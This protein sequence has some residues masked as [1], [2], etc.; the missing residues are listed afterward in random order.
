MHVVTLWAEIVTVLGLGASAAAYAVAYVTNSG[1]S[2]VWRS[3]LLVLSVALYTL[4][5]GSYSGEH[6]HCLITSGM[7]VIALLGF[8]IALIYAILE[9]VTK[10]EASGVFIVP[11]V[12]L[13]E[14]ASALFRQDG[15]EAS[16]KFGTLSLNIHVVTAVFGYAGLS[17]SGM[18]G[19]MYLML[20]RSIK[21]STFGKAFERLPSLASLEELSLW[22]LYIGL[23]FLTATMLAGMAWLPLDVPDFT[24]ADPKLLATTVLWVLYLG[25]LVARRVARLEGKR[26]MQVSFYGFVFAMA[27]L[28][29]VNLVFSGFHR[30]S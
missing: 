27:S 13:L 9:R 1:P 23:V 8:I 16:T 4:F 19:A 26:M 17:M 6:H 11:V 18:Y 2:T 29:L 25:A 24:Y 5:V 14:L 3:R 15:G 20:F 28:T 12:F 21:K 22:A 7:S 30:F 10:T